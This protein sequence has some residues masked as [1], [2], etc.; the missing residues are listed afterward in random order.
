[1]LEVQREGK[2]SLP[3]TLTELLQGLQKVGQLY[4]TNTENL[5]RLLRIRRHHAQ[6]LQ[7]QLQ[8]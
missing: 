3:S 7:I 2:G 8:H 4:A 6:R 5:S 1:M